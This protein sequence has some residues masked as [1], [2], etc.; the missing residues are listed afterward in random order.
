MFDISVSDVNNGQFFH[1]VTINDAISPDAADMVDGC[2]E[3]HPEV[4]L[5]LTRVRP[6]DDVYGYTA[7]YHQFLFWAKRDLTHWL[8]DMAVALHE[9]EDKLTDFAQELLNAL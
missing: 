6:G 1:S 8:E 5:N 7:D 2:I 3:A 4:T 9:S